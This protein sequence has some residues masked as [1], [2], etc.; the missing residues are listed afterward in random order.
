[1]VE[2]IPNNRIFMYIS[3]NSNS[4]VKLNFIKGLNKGS[5]I[6]LNL[7]F[8]YLEIVSNEVQK[9]NAIILII[10]RSLK[11]INARNKYAKNCY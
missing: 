9:F 6:S 8:I 4:L 10:S 11:N 1:M 7:S 3:M 2:I 5:E